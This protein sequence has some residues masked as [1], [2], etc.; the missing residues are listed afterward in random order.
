MIILYNILIFVATILFLPI[1]F[2]KIFTHKNLKFGLKERFTLFDKSFV[3]SLKNNNIIW[4]HASSVGEVNVSS[5]LVK[6]LKKYLPDYKFLITVMTHTGYETAY[7]STIYDYVTFMPFDFSILIKRFLKVVKPKIVLI[8]E[9]EFWPN[10]F[11][12]TNKK[13]IPI[14]VFNCRISD[15]SIKNYLKFKFFFK[16]VLNKANFFLCQDDDTAERLLLIGVD[17]KKIKISKNIK[18]DFQINISNYDTIFKDFS[19]ENKRDCFIITAGSTHNNEE[20][21]I[22]DI[23]QKLSDKYKNL[24]LIIA[25]RHIDRID[26]IVKLVKNKKINFNLFSE[27]SVNKSSKILLIDKLGV[28]IKAYAISK[29]CFIGGSLILRGG[30]NPIEAIYFKKPVVSGKNIFNFKEIY[31]QL[32]EINGVILVDDE[33]SLKRELEKLITDQKYREIIA[34]NGYKILENNKGALK[35]TINYIKTLLQK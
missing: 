33:N 4:I 32:Y 24:F 8:A 25:P 30:H 27:N 7:N 21:I 26:E 11:Y 6:P 29:I 20:E 5:I 13:N 17:R 14:L 1:I 16:N 2:F 9:T 34:N 23:F 35:T 22:L 31:S 3:K 19:M 28:L 15:N 12:F 18:F 10:L